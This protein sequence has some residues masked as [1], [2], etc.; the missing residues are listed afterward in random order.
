MS[1]LYNLNSWKTRFSVLLLCRV[2]LENC[3][4]R[5]S[6]DEC[7]QV[8]V[9]L[10][11]LQGAILPEPC[12]LSTKT[13]QEVIRGMNV[14]AITAPSESNNSTLR[15]C[16]RGGLASILS[17]IVSKFARLNGLSQIWPH[18]KLHSA[19]STAT[20]FETASVGRQDNCTRRFLSYGLDTGHCMLS[21]W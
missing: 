6:N 10:V 21:L 9:K 8:S 2:E 16:S 4:C 18:L 12:K 17:A 11:P 19:Q 5:R 13:R 1:L 14:P 3:P 15:L 20:D 7:D